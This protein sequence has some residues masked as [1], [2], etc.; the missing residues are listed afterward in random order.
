MN[1]MIV[2]N[3][4]SACLLLLASASFAQTWDFVGSSSGMASGITEM[5]MAV[6]P[7]GELYVAYI[8]PSVSNKVT[9]KKWSSVMG[10]QTVGTAG[11]GDANVFDLQ[12][13]ITGSG[14][15]VFAAKT[16]YMSDE[17][18]GIKCSPSSSSHH[19]LFR[20]LERDDILEIIKKPYRQK[21]QSLH[22]ADSLA[23]K[24]IFKSAS[25]S[26]LPRSSQLALELLWQLAITWLRHFQLLAMQESTPKVINILQVV[27]CRL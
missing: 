8:D 2:K 13:I 10:F 21:F 27:S 6:T 7:N 11:I 26:R 16:Y 17:F 14:T 15:P 24:I 4:L 5:D 18:P 22:L 3:L 23:F 25:V 19:I 1:N 12:L 20:G 9:V